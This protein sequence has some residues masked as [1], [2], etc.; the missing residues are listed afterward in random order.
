MKYLF[1][2]QTEGRGHL[3]QAL[4]LAE[5]LRQNG[6]E[7][8]GVIVND[9]PVRKIPDFF[10]TVIN[11]PIHYIKSPYF[12]INKQGTGINF[13]R[14]VFFNLSRLSIYIKSLKE[15]NRL[16]RQYQPD[17]IINFYEP[18]A[19]L[20]NLFYN[21]KTPSF[22]VGH[23]FF[24][25]HP[26]F[27]RPNKHLFDYAFLIIYNHLISCRSR[28]KLALSFTREE[29][30]LRK[31]IIVCPP[32]IKKEIKN[33]NPK[34]ENFIL[35]YVLNYGYFEEIKN[36]ASLHP[37]QAIEAFWDKK[38]ET[39]TKVFGSNLKFHPISGQKFV[40][41]LQSCSTYVSTAGFD[42][43]CEAAYLQKNILM[44]PTKNHYEQ[45]CNA[46]DAV[47]AQIAITDSFFNI[48]LAIKSQK[49]RQE[50]PGRI[51]KNW[52]D[53]ESDKIVR[54]ITKF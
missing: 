3:S 24:I 48:D 44:V 4:C 43:I 8:V 33:I 23:Q 15:I 32:L 22:T 9:N 7:I 6:H 10:T 41:L 52:V 25:E 19:G 39:E 18:L 17:V 38:D 11:C 45:L 1:F 5:K 12:L 54:I 36:W 16:Y 20:Y 21:S 28:A 30:C 26:A 27:K 34:Q 49:N 46:V 40:D 29:D 37:E 2:V 53:T 51:F 47:R 31:K 13:G 42:S 35:F 14:S 50:A